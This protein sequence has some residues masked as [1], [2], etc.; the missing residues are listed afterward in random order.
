MSRQKSLLI[1]PPAGSVVHALLLTKLVP[2]V[3][4]VSRKWFVSFPRVVR[5][6]LSVKWCLCSKLNK[7]FTGNA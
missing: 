4:G 2:L 5:F 3:R 6:A 1:V 7:V